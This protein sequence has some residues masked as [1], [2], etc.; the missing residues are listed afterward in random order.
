M[1]ELTNFFK[2]LS[3][4]T[5]LRIVM[6]LHKNEL[7]VC[8]ICGVLNLSQPKVSKHLAKLRY[9]NI[10]ES[11]RKEQFIYYSLKIEEDVLKRLIDII[12]V[13]IESYQL[14]NEDKK[15]LLN[16]E[17]YLSMCKTICRGDKDDKRDI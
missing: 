13:N 9:M 12:A 4:E 7:C 11:K 8:Q 2:L 10:V 16:K 14:L 6:L 15:E 3:D 17:E 1:K 5:R